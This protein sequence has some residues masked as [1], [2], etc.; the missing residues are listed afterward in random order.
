MGNDLL[1]VSGFTNGYSQCTAKNYA[2]DIT[3]SSAVWRQ[4]DDHPLAVGI[5]HIL[6]VVVGMTMYMCGRYVGADPGPHTD[7]CFVYNH[8][9][10][11]GTTGQWSTFPSLPAGR[12]GGGMVYDSTRN[13]L[14]FAGGGTR[15]DAGSSYSIDHLD[16]WMYSFANATAGWVKKAD[17]P[18]LANHMSFVTAKDDTGK[19]GH[20]F[21]GGQMGA[22]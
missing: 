17:I 10:T 2:L 19:E 4:M 20:Y 16:T 11:P 5:T 1:L 14:I 22:D 12:A 6:P 7:K 8:S 15:P 21:L 3:N 9:I 18:L 13:A